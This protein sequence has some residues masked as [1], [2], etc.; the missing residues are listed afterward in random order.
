MRD[1][2]TGKVVTTLRVVVA[3]LGISM[4]LVGCGSDEGPQTNSS[5]PVPATTASATA[6]PVA[7]S[8]LEG[9]WQTDSVS[10]RD[11]EATLRQQGLAK[12]IERFRP[13][14]PFASDTALILVID[15]GG[16]DLYGKPEGEPRYKLDFD[17]EY[18]VEGDEVIVA[19]A[20]GTRTLGWSVD[21]GTLTLDS[22]KTTLGS[23]RGVPDEVFQVALYMSAE[24]AKAT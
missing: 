18:S 11:A 24:F 7:A 19:H 2:G 14:S 23:Y 21:G 17:A 6:S 4:L 8:E 22:L 9:S 12:W 20:D 10:Q 16:W 5:P 13:L 15:E 1:D 3:A